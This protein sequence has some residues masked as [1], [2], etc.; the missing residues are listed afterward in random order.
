M[1]LDHLPSTYNQLFIPALPLHII[2]PNLHNMPLLIP[3]QHIQWFLPNIKLFP[4]YSPPNRQYR[5]SKLLVY[6]H[7]PLPHNLNPDLQLYIRNLKHIKI[8]NLFNINKY[9]NSN[10]KYNNNN[11][12]S[13]NSSSNSYNSSNSFNNSNSSNN[14]NFNNNNF[15]NN[16]FKNNNFNKSNNNNSNNNSNNYKSK[17]INNNK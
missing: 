1:L 16:N 15:N 17:M 2:I 4:N 12:N 8:S 14:N 7:H 5:M 11:N 9:N 13:N 6:L 3:N 10:N